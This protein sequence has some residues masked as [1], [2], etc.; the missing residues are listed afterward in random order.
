MRQSE[1]G[2][3]MKW[4]EEVESFRGQEKKRYSEMRS[5]ATDGRETGKGW[6]SRRQT[7]GRRRGKWRK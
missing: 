2:S 1:G 7:N 5:E 6:Y 3:V 4:R